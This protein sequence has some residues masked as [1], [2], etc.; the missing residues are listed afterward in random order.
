[1]DAANRYCT[2]YLTNK[3]DLRL[4]YFAVGNDMLLY[5]VLD[6]SAFITLCKTIDLI[7]GELGY[8][9]TQAKLKITLESSGKGLLDGF[10]F[11]STTVTV[12]CGV[13]PNITQFPL[14]LHFTF[15]EG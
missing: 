15:A 2:P 11:D 1:M 14:F 3:R 6:L 10:I 12:P 5:Y 7:S 8:F 9:K 13:F 4:I